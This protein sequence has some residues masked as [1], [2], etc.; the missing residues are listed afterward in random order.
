MTFIDTLK[1]LK[2]QLDELDNEVREKVEGAEAALQQLGLGVP[3]WTS[4]NEDAV[5]RYE[6]RNKS[7]R[8]VIEYADKTCTM[9]CDA[10]RTIRAECLR[11][12]PNL[13]EDA[14]GQMAEMIKQRHEGLAVL[15]ESV[16]AMNT[17]SDARVK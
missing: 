1:A 2:Y 5:L 11:L 4:I 3:I 6:K 17:I 12:L 16:K 8:L 7:W 10:P 13:L 14:V 9:L 15:D